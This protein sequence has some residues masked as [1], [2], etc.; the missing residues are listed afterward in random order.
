MAHAPI[1]ALRTPSGEPFT[2]DFTDVRATARECAELE[3]DLRE[4]HGRERERIVNEAVDRMTA[5]VAE[6]LI[7]LYGARG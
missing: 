1:E 3:C 4:I 5:H 6:M 7:D 2:P